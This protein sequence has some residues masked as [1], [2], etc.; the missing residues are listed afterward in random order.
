MK[1][2]YELMIICYSD[3]ELTINMLDTR[4]ER[5]D[6]KLGFSRIRF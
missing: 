5:E 6:A 3:L 4:E 1:Q 2:P